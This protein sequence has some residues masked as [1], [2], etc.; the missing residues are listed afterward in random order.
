MNTFNYDKLINDVKQFCNR[1][2]NVELKVSKADK[3]KI[4]QIKNILLMLIT[5]LQ[6]M[7][8]NQIL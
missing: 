5:E 1:S 2:A 7:K 3:I 8:F 6:C 4:K